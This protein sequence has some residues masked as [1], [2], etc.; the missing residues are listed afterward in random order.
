MSRSKRLQPILRLAALH[1]EQ[2][3]AQLLQA[4]QRLD[5]EN[6][7][8]AQLQ[9][10]QHEYRET[11]KRV[12]RGGVSIGRL[13]LYDGFQQQIDQAIGHQHQMIQQAGAHLVRM[14]EIWLE[15]DRRHKSLQKMLERLQQE[16][17]VAQGRIEQRN[18]DEYARRRQGGWN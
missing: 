18:H 7:R 13:R 8:L 17:D 4:Q 6:Q 9:D 3:G 16:A 1:C 15:K 2:A 12:G 11:L 14:R 5:T 10:Y